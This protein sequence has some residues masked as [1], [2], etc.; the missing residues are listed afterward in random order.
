MRERGS[1]VTDK[2]IVKM[3]NIRTRVC[4]ISRRGI[5]NY[6]REFYE[7]RENVEEIFFWADRVSF[8]GTNAR[9]Y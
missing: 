5:V 4:L 6:K 1:H 2:E 7:V 8:V 3:W 9:V